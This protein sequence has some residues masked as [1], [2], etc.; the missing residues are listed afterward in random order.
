MTDKT[1]TVADLIRALSKLPG[2]APLMMYSWL[3]HYPMTAD[4]FPNIKGM[5]DETGPGIIRNGESVELA[6]F[7]DFMA[8]DVES[9]DFG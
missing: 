1:L 6:F 4:S 3:G 8:Y 5:E 9:L 7:Y 2:D